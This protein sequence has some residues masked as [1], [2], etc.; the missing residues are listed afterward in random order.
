MCMDER[1]QGSSEYLMLI[2]GAVLIAVIIVAFILTIS[3]S[4]KGNTGRGAGTYFDFF[5]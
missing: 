3:G 5:D 2:G 4:S 1:A